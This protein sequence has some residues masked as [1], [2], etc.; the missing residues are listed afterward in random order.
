M[1]KKYRRLMIVLSVVVGALF[2]VGFAG[3]FYPPL[4]F[5]MQLLPLIQRLSADF[6]FAALGLLFLLLLFTFLFGRFY[7]AALC[8]LGLFQELLFSLFAR[9]R[10]TKPGRP[11]PYKYFPA[12][13]FFG[14]LAGGTAFLFRLLDP[15]T[16]S[17]SAASGA[18]FSIVL[19]ALLAVLV[20]F[21]GRYF[22]TN[23][24]PAGALL[25]L[26]ARRGI[27]RI[28]LDE[29][30]CVACGACASRCPTGSIDFKNKKVDN[31][32]CVRCL[33]CLDACSR[34]GLS[35]GR[36]KEKSP[37]AVPVFS[38]RRRRLLVAGG[39]IVLFAA[40]ARAGG[41]FMK[42]LA[43]KAKSALLPPGAGSAE[44]FAARCLNCNLC[45]NACPT[46]I[47]RRA[48]DGVPFVHLD[49][50]D[51]FCD[52]DCHQCSAVCRSV[53][54]RKIGLP[55]KRKTQI[56]VAA[57]DES[58]C[59]KCGLCVM[60]CPRQVIK[61]ERKSFPQIDAEACIGCG[62][63]QNACPVQAITVVAAGVQKLVE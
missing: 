61:K 49:Y 10:K 36:K 16:L 60:K 26:F 13:V 12:A 29:N 7:C 59:I 44:D 22:C 32:T 8:P 18:W 45:V 38:P 5:D 1:N 52:Y 23:I 47:L 50:A 43:A 19:L 46:K 42:N 2:A 57:I 63:C 51:G 53:A 6:S 56:G 48:E 55:E 34:H 41:L 30:R 31:E 27:N 25:G 28:R 35:F 62:A 24:C 15:Y 21:K 14:A 40:A 37:A 39:A 3:V 11:R 9:G 4:L 17:A 20:W 58:L 54:I 33:R